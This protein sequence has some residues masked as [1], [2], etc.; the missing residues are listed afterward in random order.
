MNCLGA[1]RRIK[2][3]V[4]YGEHAF[5]TLHTR[6]TGRS[7]NRAVQVGWGCA[8]SSCFA[9]WRSQPMRRRAMMIMTIHKLSQI[10]QP[11]FIYLNGNGWTL[12]QNAKT[13]CPNTTMEPS[14]FHRQTS[15]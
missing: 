6:V 3:L 13:F 4:E 15:T 5:F 8:F 10:L 12:Q 2:M 11:S 9:F 7:Q 14:K 1:A